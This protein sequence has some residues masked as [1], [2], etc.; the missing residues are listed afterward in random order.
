MTPYIDDPDFTLYVGDAA[1]VLATLPH[2]SVDC[3]VT[4][5]PYWGLRDYGHEDQIGL[6]A[7]PEEYVQHLVAL[8]RI[9]RQVLREQGTLWLNLGDTYAGNRSYQVSDSKHQAHEFGS[10]G[11]QRVPAGLKPKDLVGIPWMVAFALRADGWWLRS[12]VIWDKPNAM[13]ESAT[14]RPTHAHEYLFLL[15]KS[16]RYFFDQDAV[17]VPYKWDGRK[18]TTVQG[19]GGSLQHRDGERWPGIGKAHHEARGQMVAH[20]HDGSEPME[21]NH[22]GRNIRTVWTIPTANYPE[23]HFA[24]FPEKLPSE[25]IKAGCP[26]GGVVLDPFM[27]A[28]TTALVAR[29]LGRRSIGIELSE[30]SASLCARRLQQLSLFG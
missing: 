12:D 8:F 20:G 4:S 13:P 23:A 11:A 29:K 28:G 16:D 21:I 24:T 25:C 26:E 27:G 18:K 30:Q 1:E 7:T 17:R 6:E 10:S 22:E 14:D 2:G 15:T 9:A 5:P 3:I 19:A